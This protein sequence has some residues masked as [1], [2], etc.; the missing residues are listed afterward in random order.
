MS[1][2]YFC[3][4]APNWHCA[5]TAVSAPVARNTPFSPKK[6]SRHPWSRMRSHHAGEPRLPRSA[7]FSM[8]HGT[9]ARCATPATS[10]DQSASSLCLRRY[11]RHCGGAFGSPRTWR[12]LRS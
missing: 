3:T 12:L 8:A 2:V 4:G 9:P 10:P 1:T 6:R 5:K 11:A 7:G